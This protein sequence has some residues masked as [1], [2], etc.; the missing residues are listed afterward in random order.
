MMMMMLM[1]VSS[2]GRRITEQQRQVE[3]MIM[4]M[5][6]NENKNINFM[7]VARSHHATMMA[8]CCRLKL[9]AAAL[10]TLL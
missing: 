7:R 1:G 2:T 10:D 4:I 3:N 9:Q 6:L 8:L 5:H